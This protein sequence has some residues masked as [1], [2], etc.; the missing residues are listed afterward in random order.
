ME[1]VQIGGGVF[2]EVQAVLRLHLSLLTMVRGSIVSGL[3]TAINFYPGC[4]ARRLVSL[5][6]SQS[7]GTACRHFITG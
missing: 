1:S 7:C 5:S 6:P 2:V 3:I 4:R